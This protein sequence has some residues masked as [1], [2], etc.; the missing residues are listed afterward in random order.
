MAFKKAG[1]KKTQAVGLTLVAFKKT[2]YKMK[3]SSCAID[4]VVLPR[5]LTLSRAE[6]LSVT[7]PYCC[8][9]TT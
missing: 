7:L 8:C 3:D 6:V 1:Y 2:G 4:M 9:R 5:Q